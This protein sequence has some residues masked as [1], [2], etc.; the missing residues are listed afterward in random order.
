MNLNPLKKVMEMKTRTG[1]KFVII[2]W[3]ITT[4]LISIMI[5][6]KYLVLPLLALKYSEEVTPVIGLLDVAGVITALVS[7][8]GAATVAN[9]LRIAYEN[10]AKKAKISSEEAEAALS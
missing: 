3:I 6:V 4:C 7:Q 8:S 1:T 10:K 5:L 2:N 9:T